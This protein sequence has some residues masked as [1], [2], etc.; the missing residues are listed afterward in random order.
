MWFGNLDSINGWLDPKKIGD[1]YQSVSNHNYVLE[2]LRS[3]GTDS[4]PVFVFKAS[5]GVEVSLDRN[6]LATYYRRW[7]DPHAVQKAWG[8][9]H[10]FV[11]KDASEPPALINTVDV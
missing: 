9:K 11:W 10:G 2:Y 6:T 4:D 5:T 3:E 7:V 8:S 1:K